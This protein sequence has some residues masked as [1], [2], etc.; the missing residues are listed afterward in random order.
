[1]F[2]WLSLFSSSI[3]LRALPNEKS[4]EKRKKQV[5]KQKKS[6][7]DKQEGTV[8]SADKEE[9]EEEVIS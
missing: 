8:L 3:S 7:L 2:S 1:M 4:G 6:R 9:E 5:S